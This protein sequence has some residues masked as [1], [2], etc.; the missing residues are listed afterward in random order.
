KVKQIFGKGGWQDETTDLDISYTWADTSL[1][2]NGASPESLLAVQRSAVY[3]VPDFTNNK[4]NFVNA[5]GSH[6]FR[7][8]LLVAANAY[9]RHLKTR[10]NNGDL[11]DDNYLSDEYSGPPIDCDDP[12]A[13]HVEVAY[14]ANGINRSSLTTQKTW[15]VGLQLT[16]SHDIVDFK[17]QLVAG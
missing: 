17:N 2:G 7:S 16:E 15:G 5:T 9:Y 6:F 14:C 3:T 8:D 11:N 12:L 1:I 13:S 4:L 10:T